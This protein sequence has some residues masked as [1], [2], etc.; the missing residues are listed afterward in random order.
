MHRAVITVKG[1]VQKAGYRDL[2]ADIAD[3]MDV[4]GT[5]QNLPDG[6]S[7]RIIAEAEKNVLDE[8]IKLLWAKEDIII[9]V[10]NMNV[11]YE[12]PTGEYEFFDI[13]YD[14]FQKEGFER[15]CDA[16]SYLKRLD[17]GQTRYLRNRT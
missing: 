7:V 6:K 1:R 11:E 13:I 10:T 16:V 9:K 17:E 12:P 3:K 4:V 8:F 15:I 5:V 14:D 2:V